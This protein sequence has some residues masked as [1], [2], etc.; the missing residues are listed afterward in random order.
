L[1]MKEEEEVLVVVGSKLE[2]GSFVGA[3]IADD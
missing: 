1:N 3:G 2:E